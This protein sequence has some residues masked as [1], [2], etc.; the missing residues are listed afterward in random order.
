MDRGACRATV[1][2][3]AKSQTQLRRARALRLYLDLGTPTM[4]LCLPQREK[5]LNYQ[6]R[7]MEKISR[8]HSQVKADSYSSSFFTL[9]THS[10]AE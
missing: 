7:K 2:G 1:H 6:R 8:Q 3:V 9:L 5:C 4:L 10:P